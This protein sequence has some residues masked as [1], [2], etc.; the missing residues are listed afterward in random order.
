MFLIK[1]EARRDCNDSFNEG[2]DVTSKGDKVEAGLIVVGKP[3]AD[4][5]E[6]HGKHSVA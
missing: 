2:L 6:W 1:A 5:D 3:V 4:S